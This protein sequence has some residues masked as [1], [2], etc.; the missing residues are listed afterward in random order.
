MGT[1]TQRWLSPGPH[2]HPR[3]RGIQCFGGGSSFRSR[4]STHVSP[5]LCSVCCVYRCV[6]L[7]CTHTWAAFIL[8]GYDSRLGGAPQSS[9]GNLH[10]QL[11][12][13]PFGSASGKHVK[14]GSFCLTWI[15]W[16]TKRHLSHGSSRP[17]PLTVLSSKHLVW[18]SHVSNRHFWI[19]NFGTLCS[20][21]IC[22]T[23]NYHGLGHS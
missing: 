6:C 18:T 19:L 1:P 22:C 23:H 4:V 13:P 15:F 5:T 3:P 7:A 20:V 16:I 14:D 10:P 9:W 21:C 17:L 2:A 8:V 12:E 11:L